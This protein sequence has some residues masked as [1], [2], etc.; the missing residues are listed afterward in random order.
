MDLLYPLKET[1]I[2][3]SFG[4]FEFHCDESGGSGGLHQNSREIKYFTKP[5]HRDTGFSDQGHR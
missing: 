5:N 3:F 2:F 1:I 4:M